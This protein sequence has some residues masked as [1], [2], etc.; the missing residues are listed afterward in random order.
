M[1]KYLVGLF[2]LMVK[3]I[4]YIKVSGF[5]LFLPHSYGLEELCLTK[6]RM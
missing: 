3:E 2:M 6:I 5:L 1:R 4:D